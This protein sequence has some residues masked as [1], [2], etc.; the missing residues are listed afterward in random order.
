ME[1][2]P[3]PSLPGLLDVG[4]WDVEQLAQQGG[5]DEWQLEPLTASAVWKFRQAKMWLV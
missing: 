3:V 4:I 5:S 2:F 1:Q